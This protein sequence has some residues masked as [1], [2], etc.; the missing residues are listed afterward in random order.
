[1]A[2]QSFKDTN[3]G[4]TAVAALYI[5]ASAVVAYLISATAGSPELFGP[6]TPLVNVLLVFVK[7]TFFEEQTA[8][9]G[10]I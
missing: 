4:K 3:I 6:L 8:N 5:A 2:K 9:V 1:M 7:K 10:G